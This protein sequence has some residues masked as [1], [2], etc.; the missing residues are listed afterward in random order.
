MFVSQLFR[1]ERVLAAAKK[2]LIRI[3]QFSISSLFSIS[4]SSQFTPQK[5]TQI[6]C[7]KDLVDDLRLLRYQGP[8]FN[9]LGITYHHK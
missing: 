2:L 6:N 9:D 5:Q 8:S 7:K 3:S 1:R 4:E